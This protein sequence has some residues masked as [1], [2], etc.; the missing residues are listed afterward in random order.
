MAFDPNGDPPPVP[1]ATT[2]FTACADGTPAETVTDLLVSSLHAPGGELKQYIIPA[3]AYLA[4]SHGQARAHAELMQLAEGDDA[5]VAVAALRGLTRWGPPAADVADLVAQRARADS[6]AISGVALAVRVR[7][8]GVAVLPEVIA[9]LRD[10]DVTDE[11][12]APIAGA[13]R[14]MRDETLTEPLLQQYGQLLDP[15]MPLSVRR[16][17][18]RHLADIGTM[19]VA[20]LL[21]RALDDPDTDMS[22]G[23]AVVC[24]AMVGLWSAADGSRNGLD[25]Y[26]PELDRFKA[27]P[28][29]Y[30]D[31]W[32]DWWEN[33]QQGWPPKPEPVAPGPGA[34]PGV[35]Q[36]PPMRRG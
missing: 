6:P 28:H 14:T 24:I 13:L 35:E 16:G 20:P 17:V 32:K 12:A 25:G 34:P 1:L 27:D 11:D 26:Y 30:V 3:L 21:V 19:E 36:T 10:P 8:R 15:D 5:E 4:R 9:W 2:D 22:T 29:H 33:A 31:L 23:D 7:A 18:V